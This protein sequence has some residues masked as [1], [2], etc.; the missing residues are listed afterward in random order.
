M[1][2]VDPERRADCSRRVAA[3]FRSLPNVTCDD[4]FAELTRS[5]VGHLGAGQ[6]AAGEQ[7]AQSGAASWWSPGPSGN[8]RRV[9]V[10]CQ[11]RELDPSNGRQLARRQLTR[12]REEEEPA[13]RDWT[14]ELGQ[15]ERRRTVELELSSWPAGR[16]LVRSKSR[17]ELEGDEQRD[18][19]SFM[20]KQAGRPGTAAGPRQQARDEGAR[21]SCCELICLH[22]ARRLVHKS[23][24][25]LEAQRLASRL[26][27]LMEGVHSERWPQ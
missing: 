6:L 18:F 4:F 1:L 9:E 26:A 24:A 11:L 8:K 12:V 14:G 22:D 19:G 15:W 27:G 2:R 7:R 13:G 10:Y 21:I 23:Q 5:L 16:R 20:R 3:H 17:P 25:T